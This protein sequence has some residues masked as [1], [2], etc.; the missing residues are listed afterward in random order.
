MTY[1]SDI[2]D[3]ICAHIHNGTTDVIGN[4]TINV[5]TGYNII[6]IAYAHDFDVYM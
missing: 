2:D 5:Q 1:N 3:I 6:I 4:A